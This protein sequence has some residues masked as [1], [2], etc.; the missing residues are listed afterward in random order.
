MGAIAGT[1][2]SFSDVSEDP[3]AVRTLGPVFGFVGHGTRVAGWHLNTTE[4]SVVV[5]GAAMSGWSGY[6]MS[7]RGFWLVSTRFLVGVNHGRID[8]RPSAR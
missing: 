4:I 7:Q 3:F 8:T 1:D 6:K 2:R 5:A